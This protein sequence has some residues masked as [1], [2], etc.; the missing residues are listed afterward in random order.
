M[1]AASWISVYVAWQWSKRPPKTKKNHLGFVVSIRCE[2]D[3]ESRRVR[4]DFVIPLRKLLRSS[5]RGQTF[6]F[7][8]FPQHLSRQIHDLGDAEKLKTKTR[9]HFML[10]GRVRERVLDGK[11]Y[12]IIEL[13]GVVSHKRVPEATQQILAREFS[14]LFPR[15]VNISKENDLLSFQ[16]TSEW[17]G[18][19][20]KYIIGIAAAISGD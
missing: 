17:V 6:H 18:V 8:E 14:E 4:E 19:V 15:K 2:D 11:D 12:H 7:I 13:E 16:F 1:L 10:Y 3:K 20:S 5:K 9:A